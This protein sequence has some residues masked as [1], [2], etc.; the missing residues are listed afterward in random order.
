MNTREQLPFVRALVAIAGLVCISCGP[1][2]DRF[3]CGVAGEEDGQDNYCDGD[4]EVCVCSE[5]RCAARD[6]ECEES[7]LRYVFRAPDDGE[8]RCVPTIDAQSAIDQQTLPEDDKTCPAVLLAECGDLDDDN[9]LL[10]CGADQV[11]SCAELRCAERST[12][13][14]EGWRWSTTDVCLTREARVALETDL[15]DEAEQPNKLTGLCNGESYPPACGV[16]GLAGAPETC[17][18]GSSCIC[19][20]ML[21]AVPSSDCP[22]GRAYA[23]EFDVPD[24]SEGC[25]EALE[26]PFSSPA[27]DT[28][29]CET[30]ATP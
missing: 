18:A 24:G 8:S 12:R 10:T 21:C 26:D 4:D 11:C 6:P 7:G 20:L 1:P 28:G 5:Q 25:I 27:D 15:P 29:L 9:T 22:S 17:P 30:E 3:P 14:Q 23:N 2:P 19:E 16:A 13:C